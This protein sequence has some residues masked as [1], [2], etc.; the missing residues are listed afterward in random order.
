M[1][2]HAIRNTEIYSMLLF[3]VTGGWASYEKGD[4]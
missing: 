3:P 1:G 2:E 4:D